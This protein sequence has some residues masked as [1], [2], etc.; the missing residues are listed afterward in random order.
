M[1]ADILLGHFGRYGDVTEVWSTP[2]KPFIFYVQFVKPEDAEMA[3]KER[4]MTIAGY[5]VRDMDHANNLSGPKGN[6]A[7]PMVHTNLTR[8]PSNNRFAPY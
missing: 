2:A 5:E 6:P 4:L 8:N 7:A 3:H 1:N